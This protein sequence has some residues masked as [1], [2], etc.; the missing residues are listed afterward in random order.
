[1]IM[2]YAILFVILL[3]A[4]LLYFKIADKYNII[5]KPEL[6]SSHTHITISGGGI[7]FLL[8][9]WLWALL[10]GVALHYLWFLIGLT[11]VSLISFIDDIHAVSTRVRLV[12]QFA[13]MLL[14][15]HQW[16]IINGSDWPFVIVAW[17]CCTGIINA[18]NFMDGINGITGLY[19]LGVIV[20]LLLANQHNPFVEDS[21][22]WTTIIALLIFCF[23]NCRPRAKCFAG[24]VG[25]VGMA[26]I[27]MFALG[28]FILKT[29]DLSYII[30]LVV[31]GVDSIL[32]IVHRLL[33][34]ENIF[35]PHRKHVY[36]LM[37]NELRV[38]QLVVSAGYALLQ[39]LIS[40]GMLYLPISHSLYAVVVIAILSIFY[41]WF[42]KKYYHLHAEYLQRMTN[43]PTN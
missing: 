17:I 39:L 9:T 26:F 5:N 25:S 3:L 16:G 27:V 10:F 1:M 37:T 7:I 11:M 30:F 34:H 12:V 23:F 19:S 33:L 28:L 22:L 13:A 21:L 14:M 8:G 29:H 15:F 6:R 20:P 31:Y 38:P 18:Y 40:L 24:D 43:N 36:Q 32:T 35:Q 4:E 41:V 2:K 42:K